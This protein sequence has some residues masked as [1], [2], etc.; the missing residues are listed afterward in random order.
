MASEQSKEI[1]TSVVK[2]RLKRDRT[3]TQLI[4][5]DSLGL[6]E[7]TRKNTSDGLFQLISELCPHCEGQGRRLSSQTVLIEIDRRIR[8]FVAGSKSQSFLFALSP[9]S[10]DT[11]LAPGVNLA[12][13]IKADT[14]KEIRL[15]ADQNLSNVDVQC[16]IEGYNPGAIEKRTTSGARLLMRK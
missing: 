9:E 15:L 12:A 11:V 13:A 1:L 7:I 3:R 6:M 8:S 2:E 5:I 14:G 10:L 4:G 16:L